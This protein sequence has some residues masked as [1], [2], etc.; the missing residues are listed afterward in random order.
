[1]S[2]SNSGGRSEANLSTQIDPRHAEPTTEAYNRVHLKGMFAHDS[3]Y[4]IAL[5]AQL[6][7]AIGITPFLTRVLGPAEFGRFSAELALLWV[8]VW[9]SN[10]GLNVGIMK[11]YAG[12][13]GP[14]ASARALSSAIVVVGVLDACLVLTSSV[15]HG[16]VGFAHFGAQE[17]LDILWAYLTALTGICLGILRCRDKLMA[18]AIVSVLQ[19]I[20]ALGC[21]LLLAEVASRTVSAVIL[22]AIIVQALALGIAL[23]VVRPPVSG[24]IA[25][26][27]FGRA[28]RFSLPLVPQQVAYFVIAGSDRLVVQRDLGTVATGRY[29]VSYNIGA[30]AIVLLTFLNQSWLP[31][32]FAVRDAASLVDLVAASRDGLYR[33]L[34]PACLGLAVGGPE[35]LRVWA[36]ASF[37]TGGLT[38]VTLIVVLSTVPWSA[39]LANSR[40]LFSAS[41]TVE[42]AV[43]AVVAA[44]L[45]VGLNIILVPHLGI[46][47]SAWATFASYLVLAA[48]TAL[49]SRR[50]GRLR[51]VPVRLIGIAGAALAVGAASY[52]IPLGGWGLVVRLSLSGILVGWCVSTFVD[53]ASDG[54]KLGPVARQIGRFDVFRAKRDPGI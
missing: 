18:F 53:L 34:I 24:V 8:V 49:M 23:G 46:D 2:S 42:C 33:L 3:L 32:V 28:L 7:S 5:A 47:G 36:P 10:L 30:M 14:Y 38:A 40:L 25:V 43:V 20:V 27:T 50:V 4:T 17:R 21:G 11:I 51:R 41:R 35:A 37:R 48:G 39:T 9:T 6:L 26:R 12:W 15:W 19:S 45:N 13:R 16:W 54:E 29:Q 1:M 44:I 22:G 31:R 52:Y